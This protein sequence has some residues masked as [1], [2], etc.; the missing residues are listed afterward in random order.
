MVQ[1]LKAS[2]PPGRRWLIFAGSNDKD[3]AGMFRVL[4]PHFAHAFLT[5]YTGSRSVPPEQL[6]DLVRHNVPMPFSVCATAVEAWQT[7]RR[8]VD[9]DDL[10]CITGSVFLAG[11]LRPVVT[12]PEGQTPDSEV[13]LPT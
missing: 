7:A 1:T 5:T 3:L 12:A 2:F 4:A 10:I 11:E 6:A 9:A 13:H 8:H